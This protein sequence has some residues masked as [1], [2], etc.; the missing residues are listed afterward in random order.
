MTDSGAVIAPNDPNWDR[1]TEVANRAKDDP[2][3]WLGMAEIYGDMGRN[4]AF[5]APFGR[6]LG[7]LWQQ[8]TA[9]TLKGYLGL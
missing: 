2:S 9:A 4:P 8:G 3:A 7:L 5:A 6:W 1:L